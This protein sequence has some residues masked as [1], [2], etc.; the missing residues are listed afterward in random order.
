MQASFFA[1]FGL[2]P[3]PLR[4]YT[5]RAFFAGRGQLLVGA[6]HQPERSGNF[7][8]ERTTMLTLSSALLLTLLPAAAPADARAPAADT[9]LVCPDP[10]LDTLRP[11]LAHRASQG[12]RF[13][14]VSNRKTAEQIRRDIQK[15]A[16]GG[17]LRYVVIVG[18][19]TSP[20]TPDDRMRRLRV[21]AHYARAKITVRYSGVPTI[22]TDN[23]YADLDGDHVPDVAVGRLAVDTKEELAILVRK[24]LAY[25]RSA[26]LGLWRRQ[27]RFVAGV[28]NFGKLADRAIEM[29]AK[30]FITDGIPAAYDTSMT[31]ASWR[32]PYCPDPRRFH[33][34]TMAEL[35]RGCLFWVYVGHG[36]PTRLDR[37]RVPGAM[38]HI[39]D[40]R[41]AP[42]I[43]CAGRAPIAVLLACHAGAFDLSVDCL[44]EEMLLAD[45]GPVAVVCASRLTMPYAMAV[46]GDGLLHECFQKQRS[47]LGE[48]LLHAKRGMVAR[49]TTP[50]A[51]RRTLDAL[52]AML[53]PSPDELPAER[54]E[55]LSLFN[56]LGDP[57]LQLRYP[58]SVPLDVPEYGAAGHRIEVSGT[59]PL[60]GDCTI[61]LVCRR[62]RTTFTPPVR[63]QFDS[64]FNS[65]AAYTDVYRKAND[66]RFASKTIAVD[67]GRFRN[68]I[69]IPAEARGPCHVRVFVRDEKHFALGAADIYVRQ[70]P[71]PA[72]EDEEPDTKE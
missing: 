10:F 66:Q 44:A 33:L 72:S 63:N 16:E 24:I 70:P 34:S 21:P 27:I 9:V 40:T 58:K 14:L 64:N 23:P 8:A 51:G 18:D 1:D 20:K 69:E 37:L 26:D 59:S 54:A 55:H 39:F 28:G 49:Q 22:A 57:L 15:V 56:L 35:N 25:E 61:E 13:M 30:K 47:T 42:K 50:S 45:D 17:K 52:A 31:Y 12:R 62:D 48:V 29:T 3:P 36:Y 60:A 7:P 38:Y 5:S 43:R 6:I 2:C 41:D 11:W 68:S 46:I 32:S 19:A 53:S 65:L 4:R 71:A 67:T